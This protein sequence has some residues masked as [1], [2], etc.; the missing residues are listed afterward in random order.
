RVR[1]V[2]DL[3]P[4]VLPEPARGARRV[5]AGPE[6]AGETAR[7]RAVPDVD[8]EGRPA[9]RGVLVVVPAYNESGSIGDVLRRIRAAMPSAGIVVVDDGLEEGAGE[10]ARACGEELLR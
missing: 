8:P 3:A 6:G 1:R 7:E 5:S 10:I 2:H 9:R 4:E